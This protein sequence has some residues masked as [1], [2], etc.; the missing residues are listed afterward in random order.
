MHYFKIILITLLISSCGKS[1]L[2]NKAGKTMPVLSGS[3]Q[4]YTDGFP[5]EKIG[6][7]LSWIVAPSLDELSA[8]D[9]T[10]EKELKPGQSITAYIWMP[11]MGHGSSP[12]EIKI[13]A[14]TEIQFTELAFIMPGFWVL[15]LEII[16]NN[17]VI[18]Q[19]QS[20]ITL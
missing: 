8:F 10:L 9:L 15:H 19:W 5:S 1:P 3:I 6:F 4:E 13:L 16:E 2:F 11:E 14:S 7:S 12:I 18:D 20:P 17:K